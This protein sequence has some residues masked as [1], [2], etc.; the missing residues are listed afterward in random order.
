MAFYQITREQFLPISKSEAWQFIS[1]PQ[2]LKLITPPSM[3]F[4]ITSGDSGNEMYQGQII[5]YKVKPLGGI[6]MSWMT[7]ITH[8]REGEYFVDE[9]RVGPYALWHHQ[10]FIAEVNGGVHM[11]DIVTYSPPFGF[12]GRLLNGLVI[13][14]KL[15]EIFEYR[16][17]RLEK[18][19]PANT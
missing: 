7:E 1:S 16:R 8:V 13:R 6:A 15:T 5:T 17:Q 9:Q 12:I 18:L 3:G 10:H 4:D 11:R 2:N 14:S 19:F